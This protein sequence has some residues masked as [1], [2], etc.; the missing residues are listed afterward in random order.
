M[1]LV[2]APE[3]PATA[4]FAG[5]DAQMRDAAGVFAE[6]PVVAD[7]SAAVAAGG[8]EVAPILLEGL[9][10]RDLR[11]VGVDG[12]SARVLEGT[13]WARLPRIQGRDLPRE[14]EARVAPPP[15]ASLLIEGNVRSGQQVVFEDGDVTV[16]GAVSSGAEVIAGG[17]IHI[18]GALRGRAIAGLR[19]GAQARIFC[20]RLEAEMVGVDRLYRTAEN[21]GPDLQG[22]PVEV[23]CDRGAIRLNVI[24]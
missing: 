1:A 16:L 14:A 15:P 8:P 17:S 24:D 11:L 4:W 10:A 13:R 12:V 5:L 3:L 9:E 6:R 21:W 2:L 18:Y 23:R 22:R 7:L 19:A 20:R